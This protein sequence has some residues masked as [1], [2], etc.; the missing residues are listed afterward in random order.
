MSENLSIDEIIK[1]AEKIKAEADRQLEAASKTLDEKAKNAIDEVTVDE[2]EV[3]RKIA[4][5]GRGYKEI[6]SA[7]KTETV[8][9]KNTR[10]Q[11]PEKTRKIRGQNTI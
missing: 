4:D 11:P 6:C 2:E 8:G 5:S 3:A 10:G 7:K 9:R 1:R